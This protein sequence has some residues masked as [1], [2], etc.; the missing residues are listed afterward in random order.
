MGN[1]TPRV[2]YANIGCTRIGDKCILQMGLG[3]EFD[4]YKVEERPQL[5]DDRW[6]AIYIKMS[7]LHK[8]LK[9]PAYNIIS[10][11]GR[12]PILVGYYCMEF[13]TATSTFDS[14]PIGAYTVMSWNDP[15]V[16]EPAL[17]IGIEDVYSNF[18]NY[19]H[20]HRITNVN[21][22]LIFIYHISN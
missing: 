13:D 17:F 20:H 12:A 21:F 6:K 1:Y 16:K 3:A 19:T 10:S 22:S 8:M 5:P 2:H 15:M 18:F 9:M 4:K 11:G 14:M 7:D